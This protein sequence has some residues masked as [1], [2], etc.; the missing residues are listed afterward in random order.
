MTLTA[1]PDSVTENGGAVTVTLT[2]SVTGTTRFA[3][4]QTVAVTVGKSAD[5]ATSGTDY[6]AV[7]G[8]NVEIAAGASSGAKT[9]TL[10]PVDDALDESE[11]TL[12]VEGTLSGV[13]VT[14]DTIAITDDDGRGITVSPTTLTLAEADDTTTMGVTENVKTYTVKLDSQPT[15]TVTVAVAS[16]DTKV[17]T[18]SPATLTFT[19]SDYAAKTVTVT[20]V[21]DALDNAGGKRTATIAHTV[22]ATGTDYASETA[23]SVT[24]EVTDDEDGPS[25]AITL[26]ASP[27]TLAEAANATT[28]TVTVT[29]PGSVARDTDTAITVKVGDSSDA[30]TE[31]TDYATVDDFTLT[32]DA[33]ELTGT[34]TFSLDPTQDTLDEGTGETLSVSGTTAVSGL[35]A[36][37]DQITITDDDGSSGAITLSLNPTSVGEAA[38]AT[39]VTVTA[40]MPGSTTRSADTAI[41]VKVGADTDAATEGTD[42]ATVDDFTLT[43]SAG[44]TSGIG[45][46]SIDPT[47]DTID[48]GTGETLTVSGSTSVSGLTVTAA[49]FTITDD[50]G[51]SDDGEVTED[52][53]APSGA[54]TLA[55]SPDSLAESANA[56]TVTVTATMPGSV[57]RDTDTAITVKVGDSSDAATEGTDYAT[58]DDFTLTVDAGK[59]T[60]TETFSLDPTQDMIDEGTG[61]TLT[62]SGSTAV[63]GLTVTAA[64]FTIT[65]DDGESDDGE[66]TEDDAAPSGAITLSLDPTSASEAADATTV[67]VTATMPGSVARDTD[68]AITVKVGDSGD[69]A[70]EGTD[71]ATVDDFTLTVDA[72]QTSGTG[73]FSIDPT[74]DTIDEGTGETLSVSGTTAVSGLTV[75][76]ASFTITDDDVP[77]DAITAPDF[78]VALNPDEIEE[79]DGVSTITVSTKDG[80]TS[81]D[82]QTIA[83]TLGGTATKDDDFTIAAL[84]LSLK[85]GETSVSTRITA[86]QD[87]IDE[88]NET[89]IVTASHDS[90]EIRSAQTLTIADDDTKGVIV[91]PTSLTVARSDDATTIGTRENEATYTVV[92]TSEPTGHVTVSMTSSAEDV[93]TVAP[94]LVRFTAENWSRPQTVTVRG[95]DHALNS[96]GG[97]REAQVTHVVS[98]ADYTRLTAATVSVRVKDDQVVPIP[99]AWLARF[100]RTATAQVLDAIT[101]RLTAPR[102]AEAR[103]MLAGQTLPAWTPDATFPTGD[104]CRPV[105]DNAWPDVREERRGP[106]RNG[107]NRNGVRPGRVGQ[108]PGR[109]GGR[110]GRSLDEFTH[111]DA[112]GVGGRFVICADRRGARRRLRFAMGPGGARSL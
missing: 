2:A 58:V 74:Q 87:A 13:T 70:T 56:T 28:I 3:A 107:V 101:A 18:V 44:Q 16:G 46:F 50:D 97:N 80:V 25:G 84:S 21:P 8:F 47:Q 1:N 108:Q 63:S 95:V 7:T 30:A 5:S 102:Q 48:E 40:T 41:T 94:Q 36:G 53:A 91:I 79:A 112:A 19:A 96:T 4:K 110:R 24:V 83:L 22:T 9:F 77:T 93:A 105:R 90:I 33:G 88:D 34:E 100:G 82:D 12:S 6:A 37:S 43:I 81:R 49:S 71:Y 55:A 67:T 78:M 31:G 92:L 86:L 98:G 42:Y 59:L 111:D 11:E 62:V 85:A 15:G 17:A 29:L 65:D 38:D 35:T 52:D 104:T 66:V 61:E 89:V 60:G 32:V 68:T 72:G 14:G 27:D 75:T 20:A 57:A 54:I 23:A 26:A 51:E 69:A 39:T 109:L 10:T 73:T 103:A 76:A 45:T 99:Q 106:Q 64:S